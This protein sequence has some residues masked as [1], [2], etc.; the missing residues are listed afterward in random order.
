[1]TA[2]PQQTL[3]FLLTSAPFDRLDKQSLQDLA[4]HI[5]V[6][7]FTPPNVDILLSDLQP[8]VFLIRS[9]QFTVDE[10]AGARRHISEGDYF[11]VDNLINF[12]ESQKVTLKVDSA[13][14][15]YCIPSVVLHQFSLKLP[16]V[17]RF[18]TTY[19]TGNLN[20][21]VLN[22]SKSMWLYRTLADVLSPKAICAEQQTSILAGAQLMSEQGVSSLLI[23]DKDVLCGIVTDRDIRN[24]VVAKN[25]PLSQAL[26][27]IMTPHPSQISHQKTLFDALCL[28]TERNIHHLP[29]IDQTSQK[30]FGML[31]ASDL[32]K[33]Q[34]SNVIFI[35][36]ELSKASSLYELI[37]L[38]WQLPH[39]F[40]QH[41]KRLGDFDVAGKVLSQATDIITRRLIAF[42]EEQHGLSS[43][44]YCWVVYGSQAR[45]DQTMGSDQDNSLLLNDE[46]NLTQ[47][48]YFEKLADYVCQG[49]GKCG[50]KLCD[51]NIMGSNPALRQS[52]QSAL[53]QARKWVNQPTSKA[54][55]ECNIFLD[56]RPVAGNKLL[57]QR[58]SNER[59]KLLKQP[60]FLAA[61]ARHANEVSVP[62]SMFQQFVFDKKVRNSDVINL[63][64]N[65]VAIIN[66]LV[67]IYALQHEIS[68][69]GTLDRLA[70]LSQLKAITSKDANNMRDIWL[71]L[72]RLRWRHQLDNKVTDNFVAID[73]LSSIEKHQLKRA[74]KSINQYQQAVVMKFSAGMS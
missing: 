47:A 41:A 14:L 54:I 73:D 22:N 8:S 36:D 16:E 30:P 7:Y 28:M 6:S 37:R 68:V 55:M 21:D 10:A 56:A 69:P 57:F 11:A 58:F 46:P 5:V 40:S 65:A 49:L 51:G 60:L 17:E 27:S 62:L 9:G 29:V 71:F 15:I 63:K 64:N 24:R 31:T 43:M 20:S 53:S 50:I 42:F 52:F 72:N 12:P 23:T 33:Y 44:E 67:R 32:I 38:S 59:A 19:A 70:Y 35:V 45:D 34:R 3:D 39:Y 48:E 74:F 2:I 4:S 61:L 66:N 25:L 13:G 1:M 26:S 18:F